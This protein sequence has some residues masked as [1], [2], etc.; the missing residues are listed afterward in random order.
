MESN[1]G[2]TWQPFA[3]AGYAY[4]GGALWKKVLGMRAKILFQQKSFFDLF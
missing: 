4:E 3:R 1:V 2:N